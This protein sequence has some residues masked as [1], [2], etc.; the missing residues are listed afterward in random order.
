MMGN[1]EAIK[2]LNSFIAG[3]KNL[4]LL[5]SK[6]GDETVLQ[7]FNLSTGQLK[8]ICQEK[9]LKQGR[10]AWFAAEDKFTFFTEEVVNN[11]KNYKLW[12]YQTGMN[13]AEVVASN[14]TAPQGFSI[15]SVFPYFSKNGNCGFI[16]L[17]FTQA[18]SKSNDALASLD[19][20]SYTDN[21]LQSKQLSA[22][23]LKPV[24]TAIVIL[25]INQCLRCKTARK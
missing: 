20:Y 3:N 7:I 12:L 2:S 24:Y 16:N 15:S 6:S 1:K 5:E 23:K 14:T 19:V 25:P 8:T 10:Y 9:A 11:Q 4:V 22:A 21:A 18:P 13:A 17:Q